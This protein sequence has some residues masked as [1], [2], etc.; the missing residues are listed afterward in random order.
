MNVIGMDDRES[1]LKDGGRLLERDLVLAKV[2]CAAF[3]GSQVN[4]T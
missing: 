3:F 4:I 1:V 2:G